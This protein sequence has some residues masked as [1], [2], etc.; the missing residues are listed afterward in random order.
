MANHLTLGVYLSGDYTHNVVREEDL[1]EHIQFNKTFRPGRL[2]YVDGQRIYNGVL[3]EE[4]LSKYDKIAKEFYA[5]HNINISRPT[6]P[7]T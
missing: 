3:K 4:V 2:L 6:L 5:L 7:Y 1:E